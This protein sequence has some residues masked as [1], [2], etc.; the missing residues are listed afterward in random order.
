[1]RARLKNLIGGAAKPNRISVTGFQA[2]SQATVIAEL[3]EIFASFSNHR[4][5]G[6]SRLITNIRFIETPD[7]PSLSFP[8][9]VDSSLAKSQRSGFQ[10]LSEH[11]KPA[12]TALRA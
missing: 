6:A 1:M 11:A 10:G 3:L 2:K 8:R 9:T 7:A 12:E 5:R 4:L